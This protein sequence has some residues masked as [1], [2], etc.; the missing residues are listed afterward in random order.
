MSAKGPRVVLS[1]EKFFALATAIKDAK[2]PLESMTRERAAK[3]L[4]HN[5]IDFDFGENALMTAATAAGVSFREPRGPTSRTKMSRPLAGASNV[6]F[7]A[8]CIL[9]LRKDLRE[10]KHP[11]GLV[12]LAEGR[13]RSL[14]D[15]ALDIG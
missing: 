14:G 9:Q 5:G 4:R 12:D 3:W 15:D 1:H 2:E 8:Q 7:L 11:K 13:P 10:E 6:R